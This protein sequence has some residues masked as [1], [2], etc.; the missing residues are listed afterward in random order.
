MSKDHHP[1][2]GP[3]I[4]TYTRAQALAD[5]VL[6][7][8]GPMAREVGFR[9]PVAL[10]GAA[11]QDCVAWT[12][13]ENESQTLQDPDGRLWDVLYMAT[14]G[15]RSHLARKR[16]GNE[17]LFKLHRVPRD[18]RSREPV[19]S[20]LKLVME[21]GDLGEPVITIMLPHED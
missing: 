21:A 4:S 2:F 6:I 17:L 20:K 10:T 13:S 15:L 7:D 8:A 14:F 11:W 16:P 18:G 1:V 9:V 3:P 12:E 5:G 19:L